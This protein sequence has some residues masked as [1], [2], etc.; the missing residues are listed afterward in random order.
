MRSPALALMGQVWRRHRWGLAVCAAAWLVSAALVR[1]LP[2][3]VWAPGP[4]DGPLLPVHIVT[5]GPLM[6]ALVFTF[7]AFSLTV[8]VQLE[9]LGT[10][11]PARLFLLPVPTPTLVTWLMLQAAAAA[12]GCWAAWAVTVLWPAGQD[13]PLGWPALLAASLM[14]CLQA[15]AWWPFPLPFLRVG[16][17]GLGLTLV[18]MTPTFGIATEPLGLPR[19]AWVGVLAALLPAAYGAALVGVARARR[20]DTPEWTWPARLARWLGDRL[21]R[22]RATFASPLQAQAWL[23]W[24]QRGLGFPVMV[25]WLVAIWGILAQLA[26]RAIDN[27]ASEEMTPALV[28]AAGALTAP[29][30][31]LLVLLAVPPLLALAWSGELGGMRLQG[32]VPGGL[33]VG[34]SPFLALRPLTGG[35]FILAKLHTAARCTLTAWAIVLPAAALWLGLTGRWR[36]L[37]GAP[38]LQS[39]S[40]LEVFG[41]LTAG[42]AALVLLTWLT[43]AGGQWVSL[44]GRAWL[45]NAVGLTVVIGW[46]PLGLLGYWLTQH[47]NVVAALVAALPYLATGAVVVKLLLAA[48]LGRSLWR[49]RIVEPRTLVLAVVAWVVLVAGHVALLGWLFPPDRVSL[50]ALAVGVML[51]LP[52]NRFAAMPLALEWNRHR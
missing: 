4:G 2:R 29:G 49:R 28:A 13:V 9:A 40:A 12:A 6:A 18:A 19:A 51:V 11:F 15:V 46:M 36:V 16:A 34:C 39:H 48:W 42:L 14:V 8:D 1:L 52:L 22:R 33:K 43:L 35:E 31:A 20:G 41:G 21:P 17:A 30:V 3:A 5:V 27:V 45:L 24:R 26:E 23:E 47:P 32:G 10:G 50:A 38:V 37:A 44:T 25:G 7:Y